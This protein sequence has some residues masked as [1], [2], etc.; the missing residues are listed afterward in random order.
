[1]GL[2][3]RC[4]FPAA[5]AAAMAV[6]SDVLV[7]IHVLRA[8]ERV[9]AMIASTS[10]GIGR[11][12]LQN[13]EETEYL[14]KCLLSTDRV[15]K[16]ITSSPS[17]AIPTPDGRNT[18]QAPGENLVVEETVVNPLMHERAWFVPHN[19]INP[20]LYICEAACTAFA[21]RFR[22]SLNI[23]QGSVPHFP[24]VHYVQDE[25][26]LAVSESQVLWPTKTQAQLLLK[27][28]LALVNRPFHVVLTKPILS[29][30]D[31]VYQ[32]FSCLDKIT[33]C[34]F[35][36][37]FALGE[38]YSSRAMAPADGGFPGLPYFMHACSLVQVLPERANVEH[39]ENLI[40]LVGFIMI[41]WTG[42]F[43]S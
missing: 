39:I 6:R 24:R 9:M 22:Q 10:R 25:E 34:K 38:V 36:A 3:R 23:S 40:L 30:L 5:V 4:L 31:Q 18:P 28:A 2:P 41:P 17:G 35:F 27:V 19:V 42:E 11:S 12:R 7:G 1:M 16:S 13:G 33:T 15:A 43:H 32:D 21:T 14:H 37:L 20:P 29:Q 8:S 26:L